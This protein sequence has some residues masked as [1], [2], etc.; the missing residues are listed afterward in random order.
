MSRSYL[1]PR[2][3]DPTGWREP[4]RLYELCTI[5]AC[6][7][8]DL[9]R[10]NFQDNVVDP[11][12]LA[13]P[14]EHGI[15]PG[16]FTHVGDNEPLV[17]KATL[18]NKY[19]ITTEY[20]DELQMKW[21]CLKK[22]LGE[23]H[24]KFDPLDPDMSVWNNHYV[25][26]IDAVMVEVL[27]KC[28]NNQASFYL[29]TDAV[30]GFHVHKSQQEQEQ[31]ERKMIE[32]LEAIVGN[33]MIGSQAF[34]GDYLVILLQSTLSEKKTLGVEEQT[35]LDTVTQ[36]VGQGRMDF[37]YEYTY[38]TRLFITWLQIVCHNGKPSPSSGLLHLTIAEGIVATLKDVPKFAPP[39]TF[40]ERFNSYLSVV[41]ASADLMRVKF[42]REDYMLRIRCAHAFL[43]LD[44]TEVLNKSTA[45][46]KRMPVRLDDDYVQILL[47]I[48]K[49]IGEKPVPGMMLFSNS[50]EFRQLAL[51][52][53]RLQAA[54][55]NHG[56][57]TLTVNPQE[58]VRQ[59]PQEYVRSRDG[60]LVPVLHLT[61]LEPNIMEPGPA[62]GSALGRAPTRKAKPSQQ[63][64]GGAPS[65]PR[66]RRP[67]EDVIL[68]CIEVAGYHVDDISSDE[69]TA[70][71][72]RVRKPPQE[73]C[74]RQTTFNQS[75]LPLRSGPSG[76]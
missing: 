53:T 45:E 59:S 57:Q 19:K 76:S 22:R 63:Q 52:G 29:L 44:P 18:E 50:K 10:Q 11:A 58:L 74:R 36:M 34:L 39:H 42:S 27:A 35:A 20:V 56:L 41:A 31:Q 73:S 15:T 6:I 66:Q 4:P 61:P 46:F 33:P 43:D 69:P 24:S 48:W 72:R 5:G 26:N 32:N 51:P 62:S 64:Q 7:F 21:I 37:F 40:N 12:L 23:Q 65:R 67:K 2:P 25:N 47:A 28:L 54:E 1:P 8:S 68:D 71:P 13:T 3:C 60:Q 55:A 75:F 9:N 30:R 17:H 49:D 70:R 38:V 14:T 16:L